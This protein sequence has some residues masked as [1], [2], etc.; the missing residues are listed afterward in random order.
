[1]R[2]RFPP[3]PLRRMPAQPWSSG[4]RPRCGCGRTAGRGRSRPRLPDRICLALWSLPSD[5]IGADLRKT[6]PV[7]AGF[8]VELSQLL[9]YRKKG[10]GNFP[11]L[12]FFRLPVA[13]ATAAERS[14]MPAGRAVIHGTTTTVGPAVPAQST[15][16]SHGNGRGAGRCRLIERGHRHGLRDRH[17]RKAEADREQGHGNDFHRHSFLFGADENDL[18]LDHPHR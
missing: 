6:P 7:W 10:A 18:S 4:G 5:L 12:G 2:P 1:L 3:Q 15:A 16:T 13:E 9:N 11:P 14:G 17:R 8:F